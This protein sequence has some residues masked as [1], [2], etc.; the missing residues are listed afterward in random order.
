MREDS[1]PYAPGTYTEKLTAQF[2]AREGGAL[3]VKQII[4]HD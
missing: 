2:P 4:A 1:E 3:V